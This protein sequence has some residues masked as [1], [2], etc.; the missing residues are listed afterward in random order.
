MYKHTP[1]V[2]TYTQC[3]NIHP[4][5]QTYTQCTNIHPM[6]KHTPNIQTYTPMYKHTPN[7]EI[8]N[9]T[10]SSTAFTHSEDSCHELLE[11]AR[12]V[13][14]HILL[15]AASKHCGQWEH[16]TQQSS[17]IWL[18]WIGTS[19]QYFKTFSTTQGHPDVHTYVCMHEHTSTMY[20]HTLNTKHTGHL[21]VVYSSLMALISSLLLVHRISIRTCSAVPIP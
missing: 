16:N 18:V 17:C 15:K 2:Q 11:V 5:V 4:N 6:Y 8:P 19:S 21:L 7:I 9:Y 14:Y 3:T 20:M 10:N 13:R 1:N 12:S